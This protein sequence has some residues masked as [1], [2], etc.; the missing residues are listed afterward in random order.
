MGSFLDAAYA[1]EKNLVSKT[2]MGFGVGAGIA[3]AV[4]AGTFP[5]QVS[6]GVDP[7]SLA[8]RG[9]FAAVGAVGGAVI[10]NTPRAARYIGRK[11][12]SGFKNIPQMAPKAAKFGR[13]IRRFGTGFRKYPRLYGM[14]T[15]AGLGATGLAAG[16]IYNEVSSSNDAAYRGPSNMGADGELAL[17]I[18]RRW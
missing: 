11:I 18:G 5:L 7:F 17:A 6:M 14:A 16:A 1:R 10:K 9:G 13:G 15:V 2:G 8:F 3:G 4:Y 12:S